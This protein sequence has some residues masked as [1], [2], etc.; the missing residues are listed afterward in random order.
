MPLEN[1]HH[2]ETCTWALWKIVESESQLAIEL[3]PHENVPEQITNAQKR[4][5]YLA[6]R[7]LL[8][9][10]LELWQEEFRGL[11]KDE[12]GKPHLIRHSYPISL[13]HSYPY[14][15]AVIDPSRPVGIDLE[16]PKEKLLRVA[17]RVLHLEERADAGTDII[18]H[19]IY[20]CAK[21]AL[22]K[23]HGKKD[24]VLAENLR[25]RPFSM[26]K[27][28]ELIGRI[29]VNTSE[30]AIPLKYVVFADYVVVVNR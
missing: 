12:F 8:K 30:T 1:V 7:I 27:Q 24:L 11:S 26:Q 2:G 13:T 17:P 28:G 20:W 6:G 14:V 15:A 4:L 21:E 16:Q 29:I 5:E 10:L 18:K 23:I 25:I 19:C 3:D 9:K 22:I